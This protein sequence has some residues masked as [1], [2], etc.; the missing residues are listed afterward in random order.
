M[1]ENTELTPSA[2]VGVGEVVDPAPPAPIVTVKEDGKVKAV[3]VKNP[4]PPPP[5]PRSYPPPPPP[6]TTR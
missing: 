2:P 1:L 4:P 6:A 3:E 5:P